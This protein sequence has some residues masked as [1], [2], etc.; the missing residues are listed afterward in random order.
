MEELIP[1][2][3]LSLSSEGASDLLL[4]RFL[5]PFHA[6]AITG[7]RASHLSMLLQIR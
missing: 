5:G 6:A 3:N 1:P 4:D 2:P 7:R